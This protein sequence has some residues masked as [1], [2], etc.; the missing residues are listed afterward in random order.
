MTLNDHVEEIHM[1]LWSEPEYQNYLTA[2]CDEYTVEG[3]LRA[4]DFS[5]ALLIRKFAIDAKIS[6]VADA[7]LADI[8]RALHVVCRRYGLL[9]LPKVNK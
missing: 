4:D 5:A 1:H 2:I 7:K 9:P 3:S 8:V 6:S